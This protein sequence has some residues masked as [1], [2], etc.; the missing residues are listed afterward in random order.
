MSSI[1]AVGNDKNLTIF[2]GQVSSRCAGTC[3]DTIGMCWC[4][5]SRGLIRSSDKS[6]VQYGRPMAGG[7]TQPATDA[8]GNKLIWGN[9][10]LPWD[11]VFGP[12]GWCNADQPKDIQKFA[13]VIDGLEGPTCDKVIEQFCINQCN[14]HGSCYLGFCQCDKGWY[15]HDCSRK[16]AGEPLEPSRIASVPW[17]K[18]TVVE[19]AAA[20]DPPPQAKRKRPLIYIYDLDP[21][22]NQ[23]LLQYRIPSSWCVHRRYHSENFTMHTDFWGYALETMFHELLL[24]SPHRTFDPEEAD[25]FYVPVYMACLIYPVTGYA[26]FPWFPGPGGLRVQQAS[27][28]VLEVKQWIDS[29]FPYWKKRGG[30]DHIWLFTHDEGACWAPDE[31]TPSIWLTHWG[32][33]DLNHTSNSAHAGDNYTFE[34][35][36]PRLPNGWLSSTSKAH[37]CYRPDRDL[38]I[39]SVKSHHHYSQSPLMGRRSV[40]H[41]NILFLFRGDVGKRRLSHYSRGVRQLLYQLSKELG[42]R[43]KHQVFIGD[44][45]DVKGDY[46]DLLTRSKFCLV[47]AGDG[48]S[49]RSEDSI[50]HG[51][52]PV[53]IQDGVHVSF[54]SILD[55]PSFSIRIP[56]A[57]V[58]RTVEILLSIS[59]RKLRSYQSRLSK[60]WHR[61]RWGSGFLASSMN[62]TLISNNRARIESSRQGSIYQT[63][64]TLPRPFK[65]D[66]T[67][68]DAFQTILQWLHGRIKETR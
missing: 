30:K 58:N 7:N 23:R 46:S 44:V 12:D 17:L 61:F 10:F 20:L 49:A 8:N 22:Y 13:C 62:E 48:W 67:V 54:E 5:G 50:L 4:R 19:A 43:E 33:T 2:H 6:I 36:S 29:R 42:W 18:N 66:P 35:V 37:P 53:V 24:Q 47:P 52:I 55:W 39:P 41:R 14:G 57:E 65:G 28:M 3:D 1:D 21:L 64:I 16:R 59:G 45:D 51:C 27:S 38:V 63:K 34:I 40:K 25:F 11:S 32:R 60:V 9:S 68:D 31:V 26:D 15:G 56:E